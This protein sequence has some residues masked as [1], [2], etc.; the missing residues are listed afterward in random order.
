V[1][2]Q[3][4]ESTLKRGAGV[5]DARLMLRLPLVRPFLPVLVFAVVL[6][7]V[8]AGDAR[9]ATSIVEAETASLP[10]WG[11]MSVSEPSAT[12]GRELLIW[13]NATATT[14]VTTT[15][16][17]R[18]VVRARGD[19]CQGAPRMTVKVDGRALLTQAISSTTWT[20]AGADVALT[21]G[22]HSVS[23]SFDNDASGPG[24]DRNLRLDTLTVSSTAGWP[25]AG[26][27]FYV[28]PDSAARRQAGAWRTSRPADAAQ[29][30]MIAAQ[31]QAEWFGGWN[32]DITAAVR[33]LM[34]RAQPAGQVPALV[35]YNIPQRDCGG[36]SAG[37]ASS[38]AGYR[39][40][41]RG[42]ADGIGTRTAVVLLEPDAL[43]GIDCL[44]AVDRDR[45]LALLRD[46]VSVLT[47]HP[48][49]SVYL[50]GGH[51]RWQPAAE[52]ASRLR[53][54]GVAD[55][56]GFVLNVS[57]FLSSSDNASYGAQVASLTDG[58]HFVIDTSRNGLGPAADGEW[59]NPAGR[60]LGVRPGDYTG[61]SRQDAN[62]WIK[63]PG[64]SDGACHGAPA[65]GQWWA[66]YAL[67]LAQ[68]AAY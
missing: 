6:L 53:A 16:A 61:V 39:T 35:A 59:C 34:D 19:Q 12:G 51:A 48:G 38:E 56:Q 5:F 62:L 30:D 9:A 50:D 37:G 52:M 66:D 3:P 43:A 44:S 10:S 47:A 58:K 63:R 28:N 29:I 64:E 25:F 45:R 65:A 68:R 17:R 54:A 42:L 26:K 13:S 31:P 15:A 2:L 33:A 46:A 60:A 7:L 41:I 20:T 24:C 14:T 36:Y 11:G 1:R 18:L 55:A 4:S 8:P 23:V 49:V 22:T 21:N 40:W 27:R 32:S 57:N 67:G